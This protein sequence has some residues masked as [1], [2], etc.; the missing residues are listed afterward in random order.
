MLALSLYFLPC[1]ELPFEGIII[2]IEPFGKAGA[3]IA[4]D[5]MFI[6]IHLLTAGKSL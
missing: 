4:F 6:T 1:E 3:E 5:E 2:W